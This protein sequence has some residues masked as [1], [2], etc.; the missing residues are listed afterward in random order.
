MLVLSLNSMK[1]DGME[2]YKDAAEMV[3]IDMAV[4]NLIIEQSWVGARSCVTWRMKEN[5]GTL[6]SSVFLVLILN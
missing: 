4:V 1:V 5:T 3:D 2:I 6:F